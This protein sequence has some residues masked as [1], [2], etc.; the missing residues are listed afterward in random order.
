MI[1]R[2]K[3]QTHYLADQVRYQRMTAEELR[4]N[5]LISDLFQKDKIV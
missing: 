4:G 3:M 2:S 5:F 1:K